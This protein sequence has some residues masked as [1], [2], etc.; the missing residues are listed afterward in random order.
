[1]AAAFGKGVGHL[2][3][4]KGWAQPIE[5]LPNPINQEAASQCHQ[6]LKA[7]NSIHHD[8]E[9]GVPLE[10]GLA[11]PSPSPVAAPAQWEAG[12]GAEYPS[13]PREAISLVCEAVP[14]AKGATRRRKVPGVGGARGAAGPCG[15]AG[16]GRLGVWGGNQ[17]AGAWGFWNRRF[18]RPSGPSLAL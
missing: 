10:S 8:K 15:G 2:V 9:P 14:G 12:S 3:A 18:L 16:K 1:M 6:I 7:L 13:V 4:G 11:F 5:A 17:K